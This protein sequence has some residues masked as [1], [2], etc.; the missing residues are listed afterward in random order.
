MRSSFAI[1]PIHTDKGFAGKITAANNLATALLD[2]Y[3]CDC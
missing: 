1:G 2:Y 3:C